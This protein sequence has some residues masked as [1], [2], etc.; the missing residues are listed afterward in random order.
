MKARMA[1]DAVDRK[2][3]R[4]K[5]QDSIDPLDPSSH[6]HDDLVH[7]VSGRITTDPTVNVHESVSIGTEMMKQYESTWP[8]GF[9][10]T[11]PKKVHIH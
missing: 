8:D 1:S 6:S 4:E 7:V 10:D 9:H 3:I 11:L 5:L 2:K